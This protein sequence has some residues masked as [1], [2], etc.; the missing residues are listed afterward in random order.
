MKFYNHQHKYAASICT[1]EK[2]TS[3]SLIKRAKPKC[4][5][6]SKQTPNC[7]SSWSSPYLDDLVAGLECVFCPVKK[8]DPF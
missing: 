5:R 8:E 2:C 3:V 7:F 1:L 4:I 6:I